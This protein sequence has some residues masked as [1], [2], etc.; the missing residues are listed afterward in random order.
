MKTGSVGAIDVSV[1]DPNVI[2]VGMG[3]SAV[4]GNVSHGD[5]VYRSSDAG[6]TWKHIGLSDSR[7]IGRV[8]I[9]PKD[10]DVA[11]VAAMGHLWSANKER[12]V[13]RTRDG[14]KTW[15]N[16]LFRSDKAGAFDIVLEPGN[17]NT[18]YAAFW[19][20]QRTPYSLISGGE[21]SSI[22]KSND[23]GDT[24]TDISKNKGLP[25]GV[26]GKIGISVSPVNP[27][28]V[29]A[30][31]EAKEGGLYRSDDA[32]ENWQRVSDNAGIRQ[33]PWYYTRVYA[34]T[35]SVDT[36]YVLNVGFHKSIDGGRNF[37]T[38]GVPHC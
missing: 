25:A 24:W 17:P 5:G 14:G 26:L 1:S 32:G 28:R 36:V 29:W 34:D 33:R 12:G 13:F 11:Y 20:I 35:Q 3:E 30:M 10:P 22:Y 27:N 21:G 16:I 6:K 8:R 19:Q 31:I 18:I 9:H 7:Q 37:T 38:V 4:R 23:G 2:Y 15:Q